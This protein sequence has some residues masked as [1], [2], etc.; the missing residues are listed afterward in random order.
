MK[1]ALFA[2][3]EHSQ[4]VGKTFSHLYNIIRS[5]RGPNGCPWDKEQTANSLRNSLL[6]ESHEAVEAINTHDTE[7]IK[8]ELGDL[9]L[10]IML[11]TY[12]EE[13]ENLFTVDEM[14]KE[15]VAKLIR[16]HPHV[17]ADGVAKNTEEVLE[18]W[19][20]IKTVD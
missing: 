10:V 14:M 17:F 8:E 1:N 9:L 19:K 12:I 3:D 20:K 18:Q 7:H 15:L 2:D 6:E 11:I 5:L 16:R 4:Q 13:Q